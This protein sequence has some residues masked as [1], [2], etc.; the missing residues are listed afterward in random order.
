MDLFAFEG[1]VLRLKQATGVRTDREIA[2]LLGLDASAFNKRKKRGSFPEQEL[3]ALATAR[4]DLKLDV[5]YVL[6]GH[7]QRQRAADLAGSVMARQVPPPAEAAKYSLV[8]EPPPPMSD[9][10]REEE[11]QLLS[12][13]R[14]CSKTDRS[15]LLHLAARLAELGR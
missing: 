14:R 3:Q 2:A 15:A 1:A 11:E 13:L 9:R 4:P 5:H 8:E 12:D 10:R 6:T 7:T